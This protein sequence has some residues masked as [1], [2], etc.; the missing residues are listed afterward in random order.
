M[1]TLV[2]SDA[3]VQVTCPVVLYWGLNDWMAHPTDVAELA[4]SL[5]GLLASYQVSGHYIHT[6]ITIMLSRY[7]SQ[8]STIWTFCGARLLTYPTHTLQCE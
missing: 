5:P 4:D 6:H 2:H 1:F 8:H 7:P 3:C